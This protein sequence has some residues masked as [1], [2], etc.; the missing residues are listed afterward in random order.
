MSPHRTYN[1]IVQFLYL[2]FFQVSTSTYNVNFYIY[3]WL[4]WT[5]SEQEK[6]QRMYHDAI[7][8]KRWNGRNRMPGKR[9]MRRQ[10]LPRR[11]LTTTNGR[12]CTWFSP[13]SHA[14]CTF[15]PPF[16]RSCMQHIWLGNLAHCHHAIYYRRIAPPKRLGDINAVSLT[17]FL[18]G[19]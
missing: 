2:N 4:G 19:G 18:L 12:F 13:S 11:R 15:F 5:K 14:W 3:L 16:P 6:I 1:G 10:Q 7:G 9:S 17:L 8:G